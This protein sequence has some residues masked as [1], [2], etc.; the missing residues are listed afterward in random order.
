MKFLSVGE[1][2]IDFLPGETGWIQSV[3]GLIYYEMSA[4]ICLSKGVDAYVLFQTK[5]HDSLW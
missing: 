3:C 4:M 5:R 1:M 2:V